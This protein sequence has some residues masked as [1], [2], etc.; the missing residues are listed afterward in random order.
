MIDKSQKWQPPRLFLFPQR[1]RAQQTWKTARVTRILN[2]SPYLYGTADARYAAVIEQPNAIV[3]ISGGFYLFHPWHS[4]RMK[5]S[6]NE[7]EVLM[8]KSIDRLF[9]PTP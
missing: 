2:E 7:Q 3:T 9:L 4:Y 6:Q 5:K 8:L 1:V